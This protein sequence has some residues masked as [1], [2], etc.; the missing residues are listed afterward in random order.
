M[1][2]LHHRFGTALPH[3]R[4]QRGRWWMRVPVAGCGSGASVSSAAP[5]PIENFPCMRAGAVPL[6]SRGTHSAF[7]QKQSVTSEPSSSLHN[8]SRSLSIFDSV[9]VPRAARDTT[10]H[11]TPRTNPSSSRR[12]R[13]GARPQDSTTGIDLPLFFAARIRST[14]AHPYDPSDPG[15]SILTDHR[16]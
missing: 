15:R 5:P 13:S 11:D 6:S 14:P 16:A 2:A 12:S 4:L 7:S 3:H 10:R 1:T 8:L 9:R